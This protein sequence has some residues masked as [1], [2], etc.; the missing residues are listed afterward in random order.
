M[1]GDERDGFRAVSTESTAMPWLNLE[2][3]RNE[4]SPFS[5]ARSERPLP[6]G[7]LL[8]DTYYGQA[9]DFAVFEESAIYGETGELPEYPLDVLANYGFL[10]VPFKRIA[11]CLVRGRDEL[12][13]VLAEA[14]ARHAGPLVVRGQSREYLLGRSE[15][16]LECLYGDAAALEP[17]LSP[18]AER[19]GVPPLEDVMPEWCGFVRFYVGAIAGTHS[20]SLPDEAR[21]HIERE[22]LLLGAGP[23]LYLLALSLAQHYGLPS[24]GLDVT[25][26]LDSALFFAQSDFERVPED[27]RWSSRKDHRGTAGQEPVLYVFAPFGRDQ[28]EYESYRP[29][30]FP[31]GR[32]DHQ[33]A[34][35]LHTGW[36]MNRNACARNLCIALYLDPDGDFGAIRSAEQ[37]FPGPGDDHFGG[38]L[39]NIRAWDVSPEFTA[40]VDRFTWVAVD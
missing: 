5:P 16:A 4:C 29:S 25:D 2:R 6:A 10:R 31:R 32:P 23:D 37:M 36:G 26:D 18:S 34:R 22:L 33:S 11:R 21:E 14:S 9:F 3:F 38:V 19:P 39:D 8:V 7:E 30:L 17:S 12:E 27:E 20:S 28:L 40:Y 15:E 24:M 13:G 35:F 1:I